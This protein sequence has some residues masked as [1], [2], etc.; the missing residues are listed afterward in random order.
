MDKSEVTIKVSIDT[1]EAI[2][3]LE[4]LKKQFQEVLELQ[5]KLA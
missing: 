1:T 2:Q 5:T 3:K 4:E